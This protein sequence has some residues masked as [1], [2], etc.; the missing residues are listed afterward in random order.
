MPTYSYKCTECGEEFTD[1]KMI[2]Q[3]DFSTC[4]ECGK[5]AKRIFSKGS[6][7]ITGCPNTKI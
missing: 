7:G 1:T 2:S 4:P 6:F 5:E 3:M